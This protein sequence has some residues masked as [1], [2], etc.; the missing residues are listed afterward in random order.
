MYISSTNEDDLL[1]KL[2]KIAEDAPCDADIYGVIK[3]YSYQD[4]TLDLNK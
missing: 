4:G 2:A 1:D 3:L